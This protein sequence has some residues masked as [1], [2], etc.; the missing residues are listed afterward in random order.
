MDGESHLPVPVLGEVHTYFTRGT[1]KLRFS[2]LDVN[3]LGVDILAGTTFHVE[4]NVYSRMAKG[5]IHIG[6]H[7]VVQSAP[8][9]MLALDLQDTEAK[10][11]LVRVSQK[12]SLFPGDDLTMNAPCDLPA[13]SFLFVEPNLK[14]TKPFFTSNIVKVNDGKITVVNEYKEPN[15]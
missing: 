7:Y 5:T 10:Q 12:T 4:N 13:E 1:I 6:D 11:R 8:P 14:Q 9:S 15:H 3:Q 2:G